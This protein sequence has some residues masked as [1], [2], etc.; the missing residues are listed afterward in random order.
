MREDVHATL[1]TFLAHICPAVARHPFAFTLG[2]F[3][4]PEATLLTLVRRQSLALRPRLEIV[5]TRFTRTF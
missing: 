1:D 2:A 4:F 3:V 5:K